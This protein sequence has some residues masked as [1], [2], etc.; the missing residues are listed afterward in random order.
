MT[1]SQLWQRLRRS[2][3]A[4][5]GERSRA[6]ASPPAVSED[7][8]GPLA[9]PVDPRLVRHDGYEPVR[10]RRPDEETDAGWADA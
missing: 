8:V 5:G 6:A 10:R 7:P 2:L 1:L 3:R 9:V 4:R